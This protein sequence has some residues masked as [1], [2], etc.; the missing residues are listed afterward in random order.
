METID[1]LSIKR[2]DMIKC[3]PIHYRGG[4]YTRWRRVTRVDASMRS[5]PYCGIAVNAHGYDEFW[6][7]YNEIKEVQDVESTSAN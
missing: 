1:Y 2:G 3:K 5:G 4:N 7:K 6:L